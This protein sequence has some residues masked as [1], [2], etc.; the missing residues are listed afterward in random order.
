MNEQS[1]PAETIFFEARDL[2]DARERAR[3]LENACGGDRALRERVERMLLAEQKADQ[4]LAKNPIE[5]DELLVTASDVVE[6]QGTQIGCYKLLQKIGEGG[7]GVVY[8]AEQEEPIRRRVAL[9]VI[10]PGMD[11]RQVVA[12][13]EAERQALA[14]MDHP[15]IARVLDAGATESGRPYFVMELVRGIP[16]TEYCDQ[17]NLATRERLELFTKVVQAV[18]HAHQKGIIHRDLKP[19]NVLVTLHDSVPVPKVIDFGIAKAIEQKLTDKTLFTQFEQFIGTPAYTSPE[20]AEMSGLDVDTR[21]DI[22]SLGVLLYE[23]LVG[24]T[25]FDSKELLQSGINEMRRIIREKEPDRPSTRFSTMLADERTS[26]AQRRA[27][28]GPELIHLLKGD[29]DWVVMRCLE[30]D[31]TRRYDTASAL[32]TD[33]QN[34]LTNEPVSA[35]PPSATYRLVKLIRRN[36]LPFAAGALVAAALLAGIILSSWQAMRARRAE[37]A[38]KAEKESAEAVLTFFQDKVLAAGRPEGQEG[39]LGKDVSL[40]EAI[41]AAE[42]Q[43]AQAFKGRPLVE[44]NIRQTLGQSYYYLGEPALAIEQLGRALAIH[45]VEWGL[46]HTGILRT[47]DMLMEAY[48][49]AGKIEQILPYYEE[50]RAFRKA[51]LGADHLE[52]LRSAERLGWVYHRAGKFEEALPIQE[53]TLKLRK[54]KLGL[55]HIDTAWSLTDLAG[56]YSRTGKM[57]QAVPLF[58]ETFRIMKAILGPDHSDTL[59]SMQVLAAAYSHSGKFDQALALYQEAYNLA[60]AKLGPLHVEVLE[61]MNRLALEFARSGNLG[62]ALPL[63]E[64]IFDLRKAKLGPDHPATLAS[65]NILADA[66]SETGKLDQALLIYADAARLSNAKLGSNHFLTVRTM[67]GLAGGYERTRRL[68]EAEAGYREILRRKSDSLTANVGLARVLLEQAGSGT[69]DPNLT[70]QRLAEG[71]RILRSLI[72]IQAGHVDEGKNGPNFSG[73][74][75]L[76]RLGERHIEHPDAF[77]DPPGRQIGLRSRPLGTLYQEVERLRRLYDAW[78]KSGARAQSRTSI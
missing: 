59:D 12:R 61:R 26:T 13:F 71:Q 19:S 40:R 15:N 20:Q 42:S 64:E 23:L 49:E 66:Y 73:A 17:N 53:E 1:S 4:F 18:Q 24:R 8:M 27:A 60:K 68:D 33:I 55:D 9:K 45:R 76:Y 74:A 44:A 38:G 54:A 65:M 14:M 70:Q 63:L 25:P 30:K 41:D 52:T 62:K 36:K 46:G 72:N 48:S 57:E 28:S 58:E 21:S 47:L 3:Y 67:D 69:E 39:G 31:R 22:Y 29:L 56:T 2:T 6:K 37:A 51:N 16:I 10:K 78:D 7:C 43:I 11:T 5:V 35:R 75:A 77:T 34:Y 32:A 50:I